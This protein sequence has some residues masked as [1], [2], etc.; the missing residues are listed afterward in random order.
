MSTLA[1]E[2]IKFGQKAFKKINQWTM[3]QFLYL[4]LGM[5]FFSGIIA[6]WSKQLDDEHVGK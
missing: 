1:T 5:G 2:R 6:N 3:K 4:I